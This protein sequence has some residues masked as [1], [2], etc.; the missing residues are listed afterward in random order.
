[1][2]RLKKSEEKKRNYK[3][4][5]PIRK[6]V[7]TDYFALSEIKDIN[8]MKKKVLEE[9]SRED[10]F[11]KNIKKNETLQKKKQ[12]EQEKKIQNE[13]EKNNKND[14]EVKDSN[15]EGLTNKI[16]FWYNNKIGGFFK[17]N[18]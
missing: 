13:K 12:K 15:D 9:M 16:K 3:L 2:K 5:I 10:F 6:K 8:Y 14:Q 1:M 11:K 17:K 4:E 18:K 7:I